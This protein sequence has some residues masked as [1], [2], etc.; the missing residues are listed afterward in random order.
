MAH[1][2]VE[3]ASILKGFYDAK[4]AEPIVSKALIVKWAINIPLARRVIVRKE[5]IVLSGWTESQ[6]G[7]HLKISILDS[8]G[9]LLAENDWRTLRLSSEINRLFGDYYC[10]DMAIPVKRP[11]QAAR[12]KTKSSTEKKATSTF[13]SSDKKSKDGDDDL[14][15]IVDPV[16]S[17]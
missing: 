13:E 11:M 14:P 9:K 5:K 1:Y 6:D 7:W 10:F 12:V 15:L 2:L 16:L 17:D 8:V 3:A 4:T